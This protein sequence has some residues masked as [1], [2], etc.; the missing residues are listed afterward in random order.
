M[1]PCRIELHRV[2]FL[3]PYNFGGGYLLFVSYCCLLEG[4]EVNSEGV[5]KNSNLI[6][7]E[8]KSYA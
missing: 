3:S 1:A 6:H 2:D 7:F 5:R 8:I 4:N